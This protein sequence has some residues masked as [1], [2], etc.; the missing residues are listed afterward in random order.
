VG[1]GA[2]FISI[3]K[4]FSDKKCDYK[5]KALMNSIIECV[6]IDIDRK[7]IEVS[8]RNVEKILDQIKHKEYQINLINCDFKEFS[9]SPSSNKFDFI[10]SN[11]PYIKSTAGNVMI[12]VSR[13]ESPLALFSGDD[14]LDLIKKIIY[15]SR[16]LIK[17][18]GFVILEI[19][20]E[21]CSKLIEIL[22]LHKFRNFYFEKDIFG[23][24]RFLIYYIH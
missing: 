17:Q 12:D 10:I 18:G 11:P 16:D 1:T 5:G 21:Q 15:M 8:N 19:D 9:L 4:E 14:G 24:D 2:I 3:L 20:P 7:R 6:G 22:L 13:H 23:R